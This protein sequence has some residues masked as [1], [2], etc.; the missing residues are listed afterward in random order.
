LDPVGGR[1]ASF[2]ADKELGLS[3]VV[4]HAACGCSS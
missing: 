2:G 1:R 4:V 3:V